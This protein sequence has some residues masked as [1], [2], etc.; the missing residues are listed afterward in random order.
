V[1]DAIESLRQ[2]I[3]LAEQTSHPDLSEMRDFIIELRRER[4]G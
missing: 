3:V 4:D 1:D 2:A